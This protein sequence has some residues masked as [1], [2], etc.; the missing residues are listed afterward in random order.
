MKK[1]IEKDSAMGL[2]TTFSVD[3]DFGADYDTIRHE[4]IDVDDL[5]DLLEVEII[6]CSECLYC[7][8]AKKKT[9]TIDEVLSWLDGYKAEQM[10][11]AVEIKNRITDVYKAGDVYMC[12]RTNQ[13]T[14]P[15][16]FCS[17]AE[18]RNW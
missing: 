7:E 5:D 14:L 17:K 10:I 3:Y 1:F 11:T 12:S 9:A 16:D 8:L 13:P 15:D 2:A 6:D 4:V 18:S